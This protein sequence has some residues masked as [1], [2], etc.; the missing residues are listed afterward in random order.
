MA[1]IDENGKL[2]YD[3]IT[4]PLVVQANYLASMQDDH[5]VDDV[6]SMY[7]GLMPWNWGTPPCSHTEICFWLDGEL[8]C[9]SSTSRKELG[10]GGST[11]TRWKLASELFKHPE[12]WLLQEY[13]LLMDPHSCGEADLCVSGILIGAK[14]TRANELIGLTYDFYGVGADFLDP[15]RLWRS[16]GFN[17]KPLWQV[18][19]RLKKIYCSKAVHAVDTGRFVTISPRRRFKVAK[20]S[21]YK[22]IPN[23]KKFLGVKDVIV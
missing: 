23:T 10:V 3:K 22:I 21:G 17:G 8:W 20:K 11:G 5:Y 4:E 13:S 16:G 2:I 1:Y 9:Y 6:I 19:M 15:Y 7:T 12:R 18:K 14:I